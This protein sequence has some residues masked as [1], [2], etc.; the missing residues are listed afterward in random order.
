MRLSEAL[1]W[2]LAL[3]G[4]GFWLASSFMPLYGGEAEH[5]YRCRG[6]EFTGQFDDCFH[7]GLPMVEIFAPIFALA[8]AWSFARFAFSLCA[9][10]PEERR[11]R[12]RL[13][14]HYDSASFWPVLH[15]FAAVGLAWCLWRA[16]SYPFVRELAPFQ[17]F[18][19]LFAAWFA[20]ALAAAWPRR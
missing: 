17:A 20:T 4:A 12:W 13:A 16:F 2:L 1:R 8:V 6:R 7:D 15:G 10:A 11:L 18:W 19:F 14:T 3:L 5:A 9:P